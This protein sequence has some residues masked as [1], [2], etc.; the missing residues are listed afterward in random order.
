M[1]LILNVPV[2][3]IVARQ[4]FFLSNRPFMLAFSIYKIQKMYK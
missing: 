4:P 1:E 3:V 2:L